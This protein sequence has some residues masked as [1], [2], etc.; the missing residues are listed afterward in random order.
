M[1]NL[2]SH[3][4]AEVTNTDGATFRVSYD[5]K[6]AEEIYQLSHDLKGPIRSSDFA[7]RNGKFCQRSIRGNRHP[8]LLPH[9][10]TQFSITYRK[11]QQ[12]VYGRGSSRPLSSSGQM[13]SNKSVDLEI[14]PK[15][16]SR[17]TRP[18]KIFSDIIISCIY[19]C[20]NHSTHSKHLSRVPRTRTEPLGPRPT[21]FGPWITEFIDT[22]INNNKG[23]FRFLLVFS[24]LVLTVFSTMDDYQQ[25]AS[26]I[27]FGL[28]SLT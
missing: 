24:C 14:I 17:K 13:R 15:R 18:F 6:K 7:R 5:Q 2:K 27:L 19:V 26:S 3:N 12:F 20:C 11:I 9:Q 21:G 23:F 22:K 16:C 4:N 1:N 28:V 8:N 25:Q 10:P